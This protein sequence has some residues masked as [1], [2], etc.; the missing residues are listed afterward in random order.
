MSALDWLLGRRLATSEQAHQ[1]IGPAA[2]IPILGL[3]A[4]GSAAYGPE[5]ALTLL[6]PLG[7]AGT[8][9][10][11]PIGAVIA[12]I[13][14][15]VYVSYR[16]TIQA[17]PDGAGAYTVVR[18]NIGPRASLLAA[19]AL[20][21]DYI[22]NA[23][24]G[25][26]AGVGALVSA[27]PALLPHTLV[28]AL[29][30]LAF[31]T[32]INLRGLRETGAVFMLPTYVFV[33]AL[34]V[35]FAIG[36]WNASASGG[37]PVPVVPLPPRPRVLEAASLW[38]LVRAF[39][40]GCTA[41]TGVE[42][43]SNAVPI[44]A[45]PAIP[46]AQ[47]TLTAIIAILIALLLGIA[48]LCRAYGITATEPGSAHYQSV[49][50]Q[51]VAA[52][53][54]RG[55][56]Y[57]ITMSAIVAVLCLSANTSFAAF[58]RLCRLLA[59]DRYLPGAFA[60][61][62]RRLVFSIGI[63]TLAVITAALLLAFGG[64]TDRLIPLFAIGAL[65]AFT[66]SQLGM[67]AHWYEAHSIRATAINAVG[68]AATGVTLVVVA[69]SKLGEGAWLT[70]VVVPLLV[71]L[72]GRVHRHYEAVLDQILTV[73]PLALPDRAA[74]IVVLA[75]S[76]WTRVTQRGLTFA[77][78][79][80]DEIY[81][82]QIETETGTIADLHDNWELLIAS[83]ARR[84][85]IAQPIL[86]RLGSEYRELVSPIVELVNDL[87][88]AHPD[89]DIAVIIPDAVVSHWWEG[90]LHAHRGT[91][92]RMSLRARCGDRVM[93]IDAPFHLRR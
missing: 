41:M 67:V 3:D 48:Y 70:I 83:P 24:V 28:L 74:P 49:L 88:R 40:S 5:A 53:A 10:A 29:G 36:I 22:L 43:V 50:S 72:F 33:A 42:A 1:H 25:I 7:V 35:V 32:I 76:S 63:V 90:L 39:A 61:R 8:A 20:A 31:I 78:R 85:R 34:G 77:L 17:Y 69:V 59:Q 51:L 79:L 14:I 92:L 71:L 86:I 87:E 54:G 9:Y 66:L 47:R 26:S 37:H 80:S 44:F 84:Q 73:D 15:V 55:P 89:R 91:W 11:L 21:V 27:I 60:E 6:L 30:I 56:L 93:V 46:N 81:V 65:L 64:I 62:G 45:P 58:P 68:A 82:V 2:G 19:A 57:Y 52:I 75:A 13:L 16:Q 18:A 38:L 4:L 12:A 23:A